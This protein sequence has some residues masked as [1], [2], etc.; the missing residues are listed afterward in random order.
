MCNGFC[1]EVG[2]VSFALFPWEVLCPSWSA[3]LDFVERLAQSTRTCSLHFSPFFSG[4]LLVEMVFSDTSSAGLEERKAWNPRMDLLPLAHL[5]AHMEVLVH[6]QELKKT[7]LPCH[8][9]LGIPCDRGER[10][11]AQYY[12]LG[13]HAQTRVDTSW[14]SSVVFKSA[15]AASSCWQRSTASFTTTNTIRCAL[16]V[17][18]PLLPRDD[19]PLPLSLFVSVLLALKQHT[20]EC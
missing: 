11:R 15:C 1:P 6:N 8:F 2:E 10:R 5:W 7:V 17:L 9:A 4:S 18:P 19:A 16:A 12:S 13:R 20:L 3:L 14:T